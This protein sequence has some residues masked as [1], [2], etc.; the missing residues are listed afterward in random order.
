MLKLYAVAFAAHDGDG[1]ELRADYVLA[2]NLAIAIAFVQQHARAEFPSCTYDFDATQV[3]A[4]SIQVAH[5][6]TIE[7]LVKQAV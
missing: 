2:D 4:L 5:E 7:A 1:A 3:D 6:A